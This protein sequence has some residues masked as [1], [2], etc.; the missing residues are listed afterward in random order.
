MPSPITPSRH[1]PERTS[2][3][4]YARSAGRC[5][6]RG[7]NDELTGHHLTLDDGNFGQ[8]GH[9][10]AFSSAGPRASDA[11][12]PDDPHAL[13]NLILLCTKCHKLVDDNPEEFPVAVL[14]SYKAAHEDRIRHVT[15]LDEASRTVVLQLKARI[16]GDPVEI[17]LAD[18]TRAIAPRYPADRKGHVIDVS[19]LDDREPEFVG[20]AA[21]LISRELERLYAPGLAVDAV[22]HVSVFALAPMPL[23]VH[24]GFRLSNKVTADFFQRHRDT[25]DWVWKEAGARVSYAERVVRA[26]SDPTKVALVLSLSGKIDVTTL[27]VSS[28][29]GFTVREMTLANRE[30]GVDFLRRREDLEAFGVAYRECL[31]AITASQP[32]ATEIH[33]FPAVP[34]PVALRCGYDVLKKAQPDLVVWD[35]DKAA[36]GFTKKLEVRYDDAK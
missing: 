18:V 3:I 36:G 15:S 16:G 10:Y 20:M 12:R 13:E 19:Q 5:E 32:Q 29:G 21:K 27:P 6:F 30:P 22:R 4:L 26:G 35:F 31:A 17:P 7:C 14:R 1:I 28:D 25:S 23:L 34:A 11:G 8:R 9:I 33:L 24:M 2:L